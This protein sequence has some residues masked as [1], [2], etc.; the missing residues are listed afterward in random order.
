MSFG[1]ILG[2]RGVQSVNGVFPDN[3]GNVEL[4]TPSKYIF[5]GDSYATVSNWPAKCAQ[6]L[7]LQSSEYWDIS[8]SGSCF[9][10]G[11]WLQA[12]TTWVESHPEEV[13]NIGTVLCAGGINDAT[14]GNYNLVEQG[15]LNFCNYAKEQLPNCKVKIAYI[16]WAL[17][18][19]GTSALRES[20]Y[21]RAVYQTYSKCAQW[22]AFYLPGA[23]MSTH[24]RA[25]LTDGIHPNEAGAEFIANCLAQALITGT[26]QF[27]YT[28]Y[29]QVF[30]DNSTAQQGFI[31]EDIL[32]NFVNINF[33]DIQIAG[34]TGVT[35]S[36]EFVKIGKC[37]L[38][39]ANEL[40]AIPIFLTCLT[41]DGAVA[42]VNCQIKITKDG[43]VQ[44]K[45]NEL[46]S[47]Q[48]YKSFTPVHFYPINFTVTLPGV[49][50]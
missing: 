41:S 50:N 47:T 46:A 5:I 43:E 28:S 49:W 16:G 4:V 24:I 18:N 38:S 14:E 17:E 13:N 20:Q 30:D 34:I 26:T 11:T 2:Q 22:G 25:N 12:L 8:T 33:R 35:V 45:S 19:T 32:N 42:S 7:G 29:T 39:L 31:Y 44:I 1:A 6:Y 27:S 9:A 3:T 37:L 48:S 23:E 36:G 15:I 10:L 21:R 40:P